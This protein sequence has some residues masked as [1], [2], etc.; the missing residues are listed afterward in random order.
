MECW[1]ISDNQGNV[2]D[3]YKTKE[4][5][6]CHLINKLADADNISE[7]DKWKK[8]KEMYDYSIIC[9]KSFF[10]NLSDNYSLYAEKC[11]AWGF[12]ETEKNGSK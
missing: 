12:T 1:V 8:F 3:V 6:M 5:A 2:F 7:A 9:D 4:A 10:V 11:K